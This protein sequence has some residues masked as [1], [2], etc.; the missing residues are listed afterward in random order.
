MPK[1]TRF[2]TWRP[3]ATPAT[4]TRPTR[5]ARTPAP[6]ADTPTR[7][8]DPSYTPARVPFVGGTTGSARGTAGFPAPAA[9]S[10]DGVSAPHTTHRVPNGGR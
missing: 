10:P 6:R 5:P 4:A 7:T 1:R 8:A 3:L 2:T 9:T